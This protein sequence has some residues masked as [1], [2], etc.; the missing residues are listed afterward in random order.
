[1]PKLLFCPACGHGS[2]WSIRRA[3][4]KCKR[5]R[6]EWSSG[7]AHPVSG[8]RLERREWLRIIDTFLRDET[9]QSVHKECKLA[10]AT[11]QKAV[12]I[13]RTVMTGDVPLLLSGRC[14]ADETYV[15]GSWKNKAIHIRRQGSKRGRGTSKQ[16]IFGVV[17]RNPSQ[18]RVWL[19]RDTKNRSLIPHIQ[20]VVCRGS[21]VYTDGRKG[22]RRLPRYGYLHQWVDHDAG[23]YVRG[24]I[25]TQT[26]DGYWGLLK[27]HLDSIGGIR[28]NRLQF[29]VGE[30]VWRYNFR[31][32]TRHEQ[33]KRLYKLLTEFGGRS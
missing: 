21:T 6:S 2:S 31:H 32:L 13:M 27:T 23:E 1:M 28:K 17:E 20:E 18:V 19:V 5:C 11:A 30:H 4:R 3:H 26:L 9:I 7:T 16:A 15:G 8:F 22:Y 14:K 24:D 25:H 33:S 10:Y 29:F 12:S